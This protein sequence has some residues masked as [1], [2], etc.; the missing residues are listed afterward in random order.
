MAKTDNDWKSRLGVVYSTNP[1][2]QF[3]TE[4]TVEDATLPPSEQKLVVRIDRKGRAGKQATVIEG[5]V[6]SS[7]DLE[8]LSRE[9]KKK[10]GVGGS[11][12][13]GIVIIQGDFRDRC[14]QLLIDMGYKAKRGN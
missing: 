1:D 8:T 6:G 11:A 12:K 14:T 13:D 5:F 9:M 4:T 7:D 3:V 10:L 2:F